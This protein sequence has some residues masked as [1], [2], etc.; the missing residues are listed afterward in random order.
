MSGLKRHLSIK[1]N[2]KQFKGIT[3]KDILDELEKH[4]NLENV[5][6]VQITETNCI[7]TLK[8]ETTK[9]D[10]ISKELS[11]KDRSVFFVEV[12]KTIT[13][14]TIKD[15]PFECDNCYIA[16]QML[17]FGKVI[18]GS[19]KRG[20]IKGTTIENGSR[21][22]QIANCVS[23]LPNRTA[24]GNYEV[25]IFADNDRTPCVYCHL[26]SHP[27]YRCKDRPTPYQPKCF[28]CNGLGHQAKHCIKNNLCDFCK[29]IGHTKDTCEAYQQQQDRDNFGNYAPEIAEGRACQREDEASRNASTENPPKKEINI[30]LGASNCK[31]LTS[32]D[33]RED[34]INASI[35]GAS[36]E[37]VDDCIDLANSKK[38]S[39]SSTVKNV[40]LC[41]GTNDVSK[42]FTD[43]DEIILNASQAVTKVKSAF[44]DSRIGVCSIIPRKGNGNRTVKMNETSNSVST[45]LSKLCIRDQSLQF[46]DI[47]SQFYTSEGHLQKAMYDKNDGNGIHIGQKGIELIT[48]KVDEFFNLDSVIHQA[49]QTP[50]AHERKR[51][52]SELTITPNSADR[53]SK[54]SKSD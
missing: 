44:P 35:S 49:P 32:I 48:S 33:D 19:V 52:L 50:A 28:N 17:K 25:R 38:V 7:V 43:S 18:P 22:L 1:F 3:H 21:Y 41:L 40:L 4:I 54:Q 30:L 36:F 42:N 9:N 23:T 24:F 37:S 13:N 6:A 11:F 12:D 15:A 53:K 26:K 29:V 10:L 39:D 27:S 8:D 5:S 14:V 46:V 20:Y 16:T 2:T 45:F 47:T 34:A 31:R 51:N